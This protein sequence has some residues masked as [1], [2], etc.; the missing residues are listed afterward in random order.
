MKIKKGDKIRVMVGK[1]KGREGV[2]EKTYKKSKKILVQGTNL[3]KRHLKKNEQQPQGGIVDVP[4]PI[5]LSK[6]A[7]ICPKC[8]KAAR[9]GFKVE[10]NKKYRVCKKCDSKI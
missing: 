6:V 2:V 8:G 1:D 4:R 9:V 3:Y 5:D 10:K 7:L